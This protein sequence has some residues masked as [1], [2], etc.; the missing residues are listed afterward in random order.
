MWTRIP[1]SARIG[2]PVRQ[3][4]GEAAR[5]PILPP[6]KNTDGKKRKKR[7]E[8]YGIPNFHRFRKS[9]A[10]SSPEVHGPAAVWRSMLRDLPQ[11][12]RIGY[13]RREGSI[14]TVDLEALTRERRRKTFVDATV[15]GMSMHTPSGRPKATRVYLRNRLL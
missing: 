9:L 12:D 6:Q 7:T 4:V 1:Y 5:K 10:T 3:Y 11:G 13:V 15:A 8:R 14:V 2:R